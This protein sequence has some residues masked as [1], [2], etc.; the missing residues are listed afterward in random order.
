MTRHRI[1]LSDQIAEAERWR[2]KAKEAA[3][4][5]PAVLPRLHATE[6]IVISLSTFK[7]FY[8]EQTEGETR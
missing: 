2:D 5:N 8:A 3:A 1:S 7:A 6:A 4:T